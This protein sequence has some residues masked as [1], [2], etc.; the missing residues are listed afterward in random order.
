MLFTASSANAEFERLN[1]LFDKAR[2]RAEREE[3][4][5]TEREVQVRTK[6]RIRNYDGPLSQVSFGVNFVKHPFRSSKVVPVSE[7]VEAGKKE[8]N[9]IDG[10]LDRAAH[11]LLAAHFRYEDSGVT[12][13]DDFRSLLYRSLVSLAREYEGGFNRA[14]APYA[15][16]IMY[17][18]ASIVTPSQEIYL[19]I[20]EFHENDYGIA[21][22]Y[23]GAASNKEMRKSVLDR[24]SCD[25]E[26]RKYAFIK[27]SADLCDEVEIRKASL[28]RKGSTD[29]SIRQE[30]NR[31]R[32]E[33]ILRAEQEEQEA[34][35]SL[36][37]TKTNY[38]K[39]LSKYRE[40]KSKSSKKT[41]VLRFALKEIDEIEAIISKHGFKRLCEIYKCVDDGAIKYVYSPTELFKRSKGGDILYLSDEFKEAMQ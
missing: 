8:L 16:Y 6:V 11:F 35:R 25:S 28:A 30:Q 19:K 22:W 38:L 21:W 14:K 17:R 24:A 4:L 26:Y 13:S 7:L 37:K 27:Y 2:E 33:E 18:T 10:D 40:E 23:K 32:V 5:T 39:L 29:E 9:D 1:V 41:T 31:A 12:P 34:E 15:S 3:L 36:N 20:D